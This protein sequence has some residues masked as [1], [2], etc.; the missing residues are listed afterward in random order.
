MKKARTTLSRRVRSK[1]NTIA[2]SWKLDGLDWSSWWTDGGH[3]DMQVFGVG[4]RPHIYLHVNV[5]PASDP[6]MAGTVHRVYPRPIKGYRCTR[7]SMK[8]GELFWL[9]DQID[10]GKTD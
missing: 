8:N 7:L 3:G 2:G 5:D 1:R 10:D 6:L 9:Y 4:D